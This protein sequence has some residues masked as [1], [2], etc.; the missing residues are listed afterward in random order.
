MS[1]RKI[2]FVHMPVHYFPKPQIS[3]SVGKGCIISEPSAVS[4]HPKNVKFIR[5]SN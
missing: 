3:L 4:T 1:S 2:T 5:L